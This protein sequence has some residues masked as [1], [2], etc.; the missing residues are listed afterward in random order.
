MMSAIQYRDDFHYSLKPQF[1]QPYRWDHILKTKGVGGLG[2][3]AFLKW[4]LGIMPIV[5]AGASA[6]LLAELY[7]V[8]R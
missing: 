7:V 4:N 5:A 2:Y 8:Y 6:V 1:V 3:F